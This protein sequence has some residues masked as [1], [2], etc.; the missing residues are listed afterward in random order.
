MVNSLQFVPSFTTE[1]TQPPSGAHTRAASFTL[2][3][4]AARLPSGDGGAQRGDGEL[5]GHPIFDRV[6]DDSVAEQVLDRAAVQL[7]LAGRVL[8]DVGDPDLIGP[9]SGEVPL[10]VVVVHRRPR[11]LGGAATALADRR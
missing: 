1:G 5:G 2:D 9:S 6:A 7:A 11:R 4:D 8:G 10:D 3:G